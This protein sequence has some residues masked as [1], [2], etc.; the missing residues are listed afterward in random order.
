MK[1]LYH[2]RIASKDG[3]YVHVEEL[4][5]ALSHI[6]HEIIFVGPKI[7]ENNKFGSKGGIVHYLKRFMPKALYE[8]FEFAYSFVAYFKLKQAVVQHKPD[9]IY[10]RYNLY[11]PAGIW[12]KKR[13][14]LKIFLEV[15][16]PIYDERDKYDGI[17]LH[18]LARWTERY[19]W[20][21]ADIIL[22][23][24][25]VL[26]ERILNE[27]VLQEKIHIIPNGVDKKKF[28]QIST[29]DVAKKKLN[30]D[31][32]LVLGFTGFMR[33]WHGLDKVVELLVVDDSIKKHLLFVG[34]GPARKSIEEK[35]RS[36][37]VTDMLTITGIVDRE[38]IIDYVSAFDVALQPDVVSYASPLK[39]FEYMAL[40][41]AIIAPDT[42][43][44]REILTN[45]SNALLFNNKNH[46]DFLNKIKELC[47]D[48]EL[49]ERL[50]KAARS[51]IS[52]RR[53]YWENNAKY[54][55]RLASK[56]IN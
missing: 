16:A 8:I 28:S 12:I 20:K 26:A 49:R 32:L 14:N 38:N 2:H 36:L 41:R 47:M 44:I 33:D 31:G 30:L 51:T 18:S 10:E 50:G 42:E 52:E 27:N 6:G 15:N 5:N 24:T 56:M 54:I 35:A 17:A 21:N 1:I 43:N 4:T 23:V 11:M 53:Y 25:K 19:V 13:F 3:Q 37:G 9:F 39:L 45:K 7:V 46:D 55:V 22:P 48:N 34:D 29:T 40:G